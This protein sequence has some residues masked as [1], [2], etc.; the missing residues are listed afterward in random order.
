MRLSGANMP[1]MPNANTIF[2][3][4]Y[5]PP[6]LRAKRIGATWPVG[7]VKLAWR[8]YTRTQFVC[9]VRLVRAT[10]TGCCLSIVVAGIIW[11]VFKRYW[12]DMDTILARLIVYLARKRTRLSCYIRPIINRCAWTVL[13]GRALGAPY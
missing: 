3:M 2:P 13:L 11:R 5:W 9:C 8:K 1:P 12:R 7:M 4:A 10:R 6:L